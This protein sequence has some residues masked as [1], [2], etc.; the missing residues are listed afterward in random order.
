MKI[1]GSTQYVKTDVSGSSVIGNYPDVEPF[2]PFLQLEVKSRWD[3]NPDN[4]YLVFDERF[5]YYVRL[6]L[7]ENNN[8]YH[9][10]KLLKEE[11]MIEE[12]INLV[13]DYLA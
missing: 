7:K 12:Y 10:S 11:E 5:A 2:E 8:T 4:F 6:S 1:F 9:F 3:F 13:K